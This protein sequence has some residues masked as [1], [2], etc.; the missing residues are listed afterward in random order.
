MWLSGLAM[1]WSSVLA[2]A[3]LLGACGPGT[4]TS[5][6]A[7]T[8]GMTERARVRATGAQMQAIWQAILL[9]R[10]DTGEYPTTEGGL[11]M[12]LPAPQPPVRNWRGPYMPAMPTDGWGREFQYERSGRV[13]TLTSAGPDG[14][15]G[16]DDDLRQ[17]RDQLSLP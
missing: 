7:D 15:F 6:E 13:I 11:R 5:L 2:S 1:R 14:Q 10:T 9:Y 12:L 17:Q 8:P 16:T 3:L 4:Q